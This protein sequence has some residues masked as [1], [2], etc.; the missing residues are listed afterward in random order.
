M[1]GTGP[2]EQA[3]RER[4]SVSPAGSNIE[5]AGIRTRHASPLLR[6]SSIF[7][8]VSK[9]E[10]GTTMATL[11][12]MGQRARSGHHRRR[13]RRPSSRKTNAVSSSRSYDPESIA[14]A[15]VSVLSDPSG[16]RL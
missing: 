13:G 16:S 1:C 9:V 6:R 3:L 8:L 11:E 4:V 14:H 7:L 5:I 15:V 2:L 12:A 10:G